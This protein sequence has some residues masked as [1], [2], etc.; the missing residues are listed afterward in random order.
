MLN[1]VALGGLFG[2]CLLASSA[3]AQAPVVNAGA[4]SDIEERLVLLERMVQSRTQMQHRIQEQLDELQ[5][6][7]DSLRG[8]VE[9]NTNQLQ[10][11]LER[12]RELYLEIDK[13]V[14]AV[15]QATASLNSSVSQPAG[16][17]ATP[18]PQT[19]SANPQDEAAAYEEAVNLIL[20][21]RE[22]DKAILAFE[23]FLT[24]FPDSQYVP[25]AHY[26]W[27]QLLFNKQNWSEAQRHFD[28]VSNQF[29]DSPKRPD[30]LVKL[31]VIAERTGNKAQARAY[32]E[33][34][35]SGYPNSSARK[36]AESKLN[37]L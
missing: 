29:S 2:S 26:W 21:T 27:G 20:K 19:P 32:Y 11:V 23:S 10:R 18:V 33:E 35:V 24:R 12:Q 4:A 16:V 28:I 8:A 13:R 36:L 34:V 3:F 15:K 1:K 25:N 31:G 14:E 6:E 17:V 22:F 7:V 30:A 9:E 5:G 37:S